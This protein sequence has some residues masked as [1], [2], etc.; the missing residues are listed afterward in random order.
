MSCFKVK[1]TMEQQPYRACEWT[2][3]KTE[4]SKNKVT[5]QS[6][7]PRVLL[8]DLVH[9]QCNSII[10][11]W[12]HYLMSELSDV[13]V[14]RK[15]SCLYYQHDVCDHA[16]NPIFFNKKN[17]DWTSRT[18]AKPP[19]PTSDN[20]SFLSLSHPHRHPPQSGGHV[21]ITS[22]IHS[23]ILFMFRQIIFKWN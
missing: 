13:R 18:L 17:K 2:K 14:K 20:I 5:I 19:S 7:W 9:K 11:G 15:I 3:S 4:Q 6:N 22:Y 10:K 1:Q 8:F 23:I 12:L 21:C 16:A